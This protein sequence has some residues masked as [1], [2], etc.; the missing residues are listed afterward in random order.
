[1]QLLMVGPPSRT[2]RRALGVAACLT[3]TAVAA[4]DGT[5]RTATPDS[6]SVGRSSPRLDKPLSDY[7][8]G[9]FQTV[10]SGLYFGGSEVDSISV[11]DTSAAAPGRPGAVLIIEAMSTAN[12]VSLTDPGTHGTIIAR[13]RNLR[14][15]DTTF[16]TKPGAGFEYYVVVKHDADST[17][18]EIAELTRAKHPQGRPQRVRRGTIRKCAENE[19]APPYSSARFGECP[20]H[21]GTAGAKQT[22]ILGVRT[23]WAAPVGSAWVSC[24]EGCC[25]LTVTTVAADS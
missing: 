15:N 13:L 7:T 6:P 1:M 5:D 23:L 18:F 24:R 21:E 3:T 19:P 16:G 9:E 2:V 20:S 10:V 22:S 14:G 8:S 4:C 25:E 11:A 17:V 12:D